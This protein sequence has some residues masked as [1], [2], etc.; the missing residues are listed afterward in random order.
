M[1]SVLITNALKDISTL[2][3]EIQ[4]IK[5][6]IYS[7]SQPNQID[8]SLK[9]IKAKISLIDQKVIKYFKLSY[10]LIIISIVRTYR[11]RI[12]R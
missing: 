2:I 12:K 6:S 3:N 4:E 1:S 10:K 7:S 9:S 11:R 8:Q 5:R